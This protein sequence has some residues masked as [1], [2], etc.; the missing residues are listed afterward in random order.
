M[1]LPDAKWQKFDF[2]EEPY[3]DSF[4][5]E[6][7]PTSPTSIRAISPVSDGAYDKILVPSHDPAKSVPNP[8]DPADVDSASPMIL[9]RRLPPPVYPAVYNS[10]SPLDCVNLSSFPLLK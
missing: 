2:H 8:Q 6:S 3:R 5:D 4:T 7:S 9:F 1:Q 10:R